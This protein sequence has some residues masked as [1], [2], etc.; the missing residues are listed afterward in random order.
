MTDAFFKHLSCIFH[1]FQVYSCQQL[2][3]STESLIIRK[4]HLDLG[5]IPWVSSFVPFMNL[6]K[7]LQPNLHMII[8]LNPANSQ[9][10][11]TKKNS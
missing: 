1:L 8:E 4:D 2:L 9:K 3:E 5:S 11:V 6:R 7:S 10:F